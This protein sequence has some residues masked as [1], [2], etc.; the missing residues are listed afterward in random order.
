[1]ALNDLAVYTSNKVLLLEG[2]QEKRPRSEAA[3]GRDSEGGCA[4]EP[5][6]RALERDRRTLTPGHLDVWDGPT[7]PELSSLSLCRS[8]K[9]APR[10]GWTRLH[11][12]DAG[13]ATQVTWCLNS[14]D[15]LLQRPVCGSLSSDIRIRGKEMWTWGC[16]ASLLLQAQDQ[17]SH[18]E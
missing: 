6:P 18:T 11:G 1:M 9:H 14:G 5:A 8:L 2:I 3:A 15:Y 10:S 7:S 16:G 13:T 12:S 17:P 4:A